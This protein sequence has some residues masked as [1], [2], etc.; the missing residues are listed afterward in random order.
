M[1]NPIMIGERVYLRPL[2]AGDGE[3][4]ARHHATETENFMIRERFLASPIGSE[5]W[6]AKLHE[7]QPPSEIELAV[8]LTAD[9]Q[10]IGSV[11]IEDID[12]VNRTAETGSW[13]TRPEY[14]GQGYGTEAK[15][16]LLEYVFDQLQFHILV[17]DR[18]GAEHAL[19]GG[20][21]QARL[22]PGRSAPLVRDQ[23]RRLP[24][25]ARLR[26]YPRRMAGRPRC[27]AR[28]PRAGIGRQRIIRVGAGTHPRS[29]HEGGDSHERAPSSPASH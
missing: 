4:F 25:H 14:R 24:R 18:L 5:H 16:L 9:D 15:H 10:L 7:H 21:G 27:L 2:E 20:A 26:R 6:I 22:P 29:A 23:E 11:G 3:E 19:G 17:V 8:C 28:Q 1:R 13:L 12:W